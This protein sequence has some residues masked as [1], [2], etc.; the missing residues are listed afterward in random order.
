MVQEQGRHPRQHTILETCLFIAK[1]IVR[2]WQQHSVASRGSPLKAKSTLSSCPS[3]LGVGEASASQVEPEPFDF[4]LTEGVE[5]QKLDE[6]SQ[7]LQ[8]QDII[9]GCS[10]PPLV[11][12]YA[13]R[14]EDFLDGLGLCS[15]GRW[16]P[17]ARSRRKSSE[18]LGFAS[19]IRNMVDEFCLTKIKDLPRQTFEL[20]QGRYKSSPFD[21]GGLEDLRNR[22]FRLLPDPRQAEVLVPGQP[23]YLHALAQS[24]RLLGDLDVDIIDSFFAGAYLSG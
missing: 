19:S 20:A 15:P 12:R 5:D 7:D 14:S 1:G 11:A 2:T 6:S 10:G 24:L 3:N 4:Q 18:Q 8:H 13:G 16:H 9:S 21:E 22:W 23:F 17:S